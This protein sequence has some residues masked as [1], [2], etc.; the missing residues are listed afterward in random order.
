MPQQHFVAEINSNNQPGINNMNSKTPTA[1]LNAN[2]LVN[3]FNWADSKEGWS[4]W[5]AIYNQLL[6]LEGSME[7]EL[8]VL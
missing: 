6:N 4:Y 5:V 2:R 3:A 7:Q 8:Q 1:Q